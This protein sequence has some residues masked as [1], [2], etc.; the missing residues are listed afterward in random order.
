MLRARNSR[1]IRKKR[2]ERTVIEAQTQAVKDADRAARGALDDAATQTREL[3]AGVRGVDGAM[4]LLEKDLV[5]HRKQQAEL[6]R[7]AGAAKTCYDVSVV[8]DYA[9]T[10]LSA[11]SLTALTEYDTSNLKVATKQ[12]QDALVLA[13]KT[14]GGLQAAAQAYRSVPA[15]NPR[16]QARL[17]FQPGQITQAQTALGAAMKT[18]NAAL[19]S[20]H[21]RHKAI[22]AEAHALVDQAKAVAGKLTCQPES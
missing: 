13:Q 21:A 7:T 9:L 5:S 17:S 14:L 8:Q 3:Q 19:A 20:T 15:A 18:A 1:S 10:S 6:L 4:K 2:A 22:L 12:V 11:Y 16:A